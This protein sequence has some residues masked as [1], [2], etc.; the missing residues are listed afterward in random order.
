MARLNVCACLCVSK[1]HHTINYFLFILVFTVL[2]NVD[3]LSPMKA[4]PGVPYST[5]SHSLS[6]EL[7][8]SIFIVV[9]KYGL[10]DPI[11]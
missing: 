5:G 1:E 4:S 6:C 10:A 8:V 7:V 11:C 3:S 2:S 9:C